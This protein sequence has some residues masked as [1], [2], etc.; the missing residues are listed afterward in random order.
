MDMYFLLLIFYTN[1]QRTAQDKCFK[2]DSR[3]HDESGLRQDED[4]D[5]RHNHAIEK[6]V[7]RWEPA[8][9]SKDQYDNQIKRHYIKYG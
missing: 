8:G 7:Y 1:F 9:K 4:I 6:I 2:C 3:T 5:V